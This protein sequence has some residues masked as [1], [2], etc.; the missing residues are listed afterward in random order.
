MY[1]TIISSCSFRAGPIVNNFQLC[2]SRNILLM[3]KKTSL[4]YINMTA[5]GGRC[6]N[7]NREKLVKP[8]PIVMRYL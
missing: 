8:N 4:N 2:I 5:G 1:F 6:R 7:G 3:E